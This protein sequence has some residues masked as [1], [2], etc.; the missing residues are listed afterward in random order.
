ME[1]WNVFHNIH[2]KYIY[3]RFVEVFNYLRESLRTTYVYACFHQ[4]Q[5]RYVVRLKFVVI[6]NRTVVRRKSIKK[7]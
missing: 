5:E 7:L 1:S 6:R 2:N 4:Y 3:K